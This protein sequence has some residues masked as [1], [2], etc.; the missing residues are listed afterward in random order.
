M[1]KKK[2]CKV[3]KMFVESDVCPLGKKG[4]D[5]GAHNDGQVTESWKG[6]VYIADA[7]RSLIAEKIN[8]KVKGEYA[9]KVQ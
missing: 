1:A 3:C 4:S 6:R 8:A 9:I 2:V 5:C 7:A